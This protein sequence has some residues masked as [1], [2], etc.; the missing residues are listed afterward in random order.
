M[1]RII[2]ILAII[3]FFSNSVN[4][5]LPS[6]NNSEYN[7]VNKRVGM[8]YNNGIYSK[9]KGNTS[10][11]ELNS[12]PYNH[13]FQSGPHNTYEHYEPKLELR[14][15]EDYLLKVS[16]LIEIDIHQSDN[17]DW[18]VYHKKDNEEVNCGAEGLGK[19]VTL[20]TT[21][22]VIKSF[23]DKNPNHHVITL[24][25]ELKGANIWGKDNPEDLNKI[26]EEH[27]TDNF[28]YSPSNF[29]AK[30][31]SSNL[32]DA[33]NNGWPTLGELKGKIII[34][35]FN[36]NQPNSL[37]LEYN[38]FNRGYAFVAPNMYGT[39]GAG[40]V[41]LPSC[42]TSRTKKD[43]IF[44]S[45]KGNSYADHCYGLEIFRTNRVSSTFYVNST[46]GS[47]PGVSEYRDFLIQH[48]RWGKGKN[49]ESHN[50]NYHYSGSLIN[51]NNTRAIV[52]FKSGNKYLIAK[53]DILELK[54][55]E[56]SKATN[57]AAVDVWIDYDS[58]GQF[59]LL[60]KDSNRAYLIQPV[61]GMDGEN[62]NE[63]IIE[64]K[65]EYSSKN[66]NIKNREVILYTREYTDKKTRSKDQYWMFEEQKN[67]EIVIKNK[68]YNL[69][70]G[71]GSINSLELKKNIK[72]AIR[73]V[74]E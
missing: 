49:V 28:I 46:E 56:T 37:L 74:V 14:R 50:Q 38:E 45:L 10:Q 13:W 65:G 25:L 64:V 26:F 41:D 52:K 3:L 40:N 47:T 12:V 62:P 68:F 73:W 67:G 19:E 57:F 36:H 44:Y 42:F 66:K 6:F 8:I 32:R 71:E 5:Q 29:L 7:D 72:E 18:L 21:L 53:N 58:K 55:C 35:L 11:A 54:E 70:I 63:K 4:A 16:S 20:S 24:W 59:P 9:S 69:Y 1:K 34:V 51:S 61:T 22:D 23:H 31:N 27:L 30:N 15:I 33:A 60:S 43:V 2:T 48:A 39:N 17:H